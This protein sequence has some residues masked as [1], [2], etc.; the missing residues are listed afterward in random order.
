M[1]GQPSS[2]NGPI[3]GINVTPL[4]DVMLVL[5]VIFMVTA[6]LVVAPQQALPM[7]LPHAASGEAVQTVLSIALAKDGATFVNGQLVQNDEAIHPLAQGVQAEHPDVRAVIQADAAVPHGRV[8]HVM[9]VLSRTHISQIAFA[10]EAEA[11]T[12]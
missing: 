5:L 6:K 8:I 3:N 4:V 9:D 2:G 10:V 12:P 7:D 11:A 1:A